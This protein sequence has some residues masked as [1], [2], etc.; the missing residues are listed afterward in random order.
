MCAEPVPACHNNS[1]C[2]ELNHD[3]TITKNLSVD[4]DMDDEWLMKVADVKS[5]NVLNS[6]RSS[7]KGREGSCSSFKG[8]EGS[9]AAD[10]KG[11]HIII[12]DFLPSVSVC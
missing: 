6:L 10:G 3:K 4:E 5:M 12:E 9:C 1:C 11:G 8:R 7:F 2:R